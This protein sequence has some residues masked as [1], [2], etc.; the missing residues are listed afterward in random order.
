MPRHEGYG[1]PDVPP[2][3]RRQ[4][5][6]LVAD[7]SASVAANLVGVYLHGSLA[8]G[9]FRPQRRD[10]DLL[11]V[12]RHPLRRSE[13]ARVAQAFLRHSGPKAWPRTPPY[14]CEATVLSEGQLRPWRYP[15]TFD[16]HFA[17]GARE[18]FE[19][20]DFASRRSTDSD[21]AAHATVLHASGV[22][23]TGLPVRDVFPPVPRADFVAHLHEEIAW[24]RDHAVP[25][26]A[27]LTVSRAWA[28]LS[29][30]RSPSK[31]AGGEW[32]LLRAPAEFRPSIERALAVYTGELEE[33][34][35]DRE[36]VSRYIDFV[37]QQV[38][39]AA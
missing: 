35:F 19:R 32:A 22:A 27:L 16:L 25:F 10:I 31:Q 21:L 38:G 9:C 15:P 8:F 26:Y 7:L 5:E 13:R 30:E 6:S 4:V 14:P 3:V 33:A 36:V 1:W 37:G 39:S 20:G 23:L 29:E 18:R 2:D 12:T 11:V 24:C 28:T 34:S 17:E